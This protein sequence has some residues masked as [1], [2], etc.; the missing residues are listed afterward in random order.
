MTLED[1]IRAIVV[2]VVRDELA[3]ARAGTAPDEYL[4]TAGAGRLADVAAGTIRRWIREGRLAE[5]RAGR[6]VRVRRV[7][8]VELM[9][10]GRRD[11]DDSPEAKALRDF[12]G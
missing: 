11:R 2:E 7:D 10:S 9:R 8:L 12:G 1:Q 5:H 3:K 6:V 4:S